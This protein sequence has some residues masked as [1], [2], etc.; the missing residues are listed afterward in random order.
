MNIQS[1]VPKDTSPDVQLD[2]HLSCDIAGE[3]Y[4]F[5]IDEFADNALHLVNTKALH[6]LSHEVDELRQAALW[7]L[8][9]QVG[10]V[11]LQLQS[12]SPQPGTIVAHSQNNAT[13]DLIWHA[14]YEKQNGLAARDTPSHR[15]DNVPQ[16]GQY[17]ER[18]R[19]K[20]LEFVREKTGA[21]LDQVSVSSLDAGELRGNLESYIGS[22][23]IPVGLAG[24]LCIQGEYA[25]GVFYAP[26]AT[27]EGALVASITRGARALTQSGAVNTCV[28]AQQMIRVPAFVFAN[29]DSARL[30]STW[31]HDHA[32]A[33]QSKVLEY[34]NHG[35][36]KNLYTK[37]LG[38]TVYAYFVYETGDA[39]GQNMVTTCTWNTCLWVLERLRVIEHL[40]VE[41][42]MIESSLSGD[43]RASYQSF[44]NGRGLSAQAEAFLPANILSRFLKVTPQELF[45]GYQRFVEGAVHLGMVGLNVN[46]SNLLAGIFAATGQDI[47]CVHE[48]SVA[49]LHM[50][51]M[52]NGIYTYLKLPNLA[53]GTVGGGTGLPQQRECLEIIGCV[54]SGKVRKLAEIIT[55]FCLALDLS[56]LSALV[57]GQFAVAH[58]RLGRNRPVQYLSPQDM[59][60]D[61]FTQVVSSTLNDAG[62]KVTQAVPVAHVEMGSSIITELSKQGDDKLIGHFPYRMRFESPGGGGTCEREVMV[63]SKP[64]DAEVIQMVNNLAT[65]GHAELSSEF[66]RYGGKIDLLGCHVR[67]LAIYQQQ[68]ERFKRYTP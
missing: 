54:G 30:F 63:K 18:A 9:R 61:F 22:V 27:T 21:R 12:A 42:F 46:V 37:I 41:N 6:G 50:E 26:V 28:F 4:V 59:H 2:A 7:V 34:T 24:P 16:R 36:L 8:G 25:R 15:A 52:D 43:K 60:T 23:E 66:K 55:A 35:E 49:H 11:D 10:T 38:R 33:I 13:S 48:C 58:E 67:E 51:L 20:R 68:D 1:T 32:E 56:T 62:L 19:Q 39:A 45:A 40:Q 5:P 17:T 65:L 31:L 29:M 3:T 64:T 14:R 44:I 53:L 47:A 57:G